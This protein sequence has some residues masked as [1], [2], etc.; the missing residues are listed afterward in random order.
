MTAL[1][2]LGSHHLRRGALLGCLG[3]LT[4]LA[5][6]FAPVDAH[7]AAKIQGTVFE[8]L[9]YGG[10]AGRDLITS[11]GIGVL[12]ARIEA[13][14]LATGEFAGASNIDT[15]GAYSLNGLNAGS[16]IV[17]VVC[18]SVTSSRLGYSPGLHLA[19][20]TFAT[21]RPGV[22][23]IPVTNLV[24]GH[25]P[26]QIDAPDAGSNDF[27]DP[28][29][30]QF[31][32]GPVGYAQT[33][34]VVNVPTSNSILTGI[35]FGFSFNVVSNTNDD[36]MGSFRQFLINA[37]GLDHTGLA[38]DGLTPGVD[39]AVFMISNGTAA[40]GLRA[41]NDYFV[42]GVA[43]IA[44]QSTLPPLDATVSIDAQNQPGWSQDPIVMLDGSATFGAN[45]LLVQSPDC[46]IRGLI[47][48]GFGASGISVNDVDAVIQGNWIGLDATGTAAL[49][50]GTDGIE[51]W[52]DRAIVGGTSASQRNV[53]SGNAN[54]GIRVE[55]LS[56]QSV[57]RGNWVGTNATG[58]AAVP[59]G[60]LGGTF[61]AIL[62]TGDNTTVGG[63]SAGARNLVS[64]NTG[65]GIEVSGFANVIRGNGI[66]VDANG[67]PLGNAGN[68]ILV[69][70]LFGGLNLQIG[71]VVAGTGNEIKNNG[72]S[73]IAT[74]LN[75]DGVSLLRNAIDDNALLG[76]DLLADGITANDPGD[77]DTGPNGLQNFP[78]VTLARTSEQDVRLQGTFESTANTAFRFELFA[79]PLADASGNGEGA[80]F[81]A[82]FNGSTDGLG[83]LAIDTLLTGVVNL[84]ESVS[85]TATSLALNN[86]SEFSGAF[87]STDAYGII[88]S[89]TA[90]LVT[91]EPGDSASFTV[92]LE[93]R[94]SSPVTI[95]LVSLD[96]TEGAPTVPSIT[97]TSTDWNIPQTV[98]VKGVN[99][100]VMDGDQA[101]TLE[102]QPAVSSDPKYNGRDADDVAVSNTDED[103]A[104]ITVTPT[105]GL[106]TTEAGGSDV[107]TVQLDTEPVADVVITL[108]TDTATEGVTDVDTLTFTAS[109]WNVPQ[110]VTVSGVNDF[111]VDGDTPFSIVL[112]AATS[113][114]PN[115]DTMDPAD[116]FVT[117]ADD[118]VAGV[119]F[120]PVLGLTT[121][122]NGGFSTV[123]VRLTA[124]PAAAVTFS[125]ASS[126]TTEGA[127]SPTSLTFTAADWNVDQVVTLN[128]V[129][130]VIVDGVQSWTV[131]TG[132][133]V[134]SDP[135]FDT[136]AVDD[137]TVDNA[138][139]DVADATA[140]PAAGL[141]TAEDGTP[142]T[143]TVVLT[144]MPS[145]PVTIPVSSDDTTEGTISP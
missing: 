99:D 106:A 20:P 119:A 10:G 134:S 30:F 129:N 138:D 55:F 131:L 116:V 51:V 102:L 62:V 12:D 80:R 78:D 70:D 74:M 125:L 140:T 54:H 27:I 35:D 90:G 33:A 50:N 15:L 36:G 120:D 57:V 22:T 141:V 2:E 29:T 121:D 7:A 9:N 3:L 4:V 101:W 8:D 63:A 75:V 46:V 52:T 1:V 123:N 79:S 108:A 69:S 126:D 41:S 48:S 40:P 100:F 145:A 28:V 43:S 107:F 111:V 87:T 26:A 91:S 31:V 118:D 66:G 117:N 81:V 25:L 135:I 84:G 61:A 17:R 23:E 77:A 59:N 112:A 88:V 133:L 44:L 6:V 98:W 143:F 16:Y 95:G 86:T 142:A 11:G 128:G 113:A 19:V 67:S 45:G 72:G 105:G 97:F 73:G 130:D 39:N 18:A 82:A 103:V 93:Y 83:Q 115:Y 65:A 124:M 122:E 56:S 58:T 96:P 21:E 32:S 14:D 13:F 47:V 139:N 92:V 109:N 104:G 64:G 60:D 37:S 85:M 89:P 53:V 137:L 144:S 114:D 127:V 42:G 94:P 76:I 34:V 38:Q 136:V 24:G 71:G 5:A 68:G 132:D 49:A 110:T